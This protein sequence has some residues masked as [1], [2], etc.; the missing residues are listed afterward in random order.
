MALAYAEMFAVEF[1]AR[2]V[3]VAVKGRPSAAL[4]YRLGAKTLADCLA[5]ERA[6]I[7]SGNTH[8]VTALVE[9]RA[10]KL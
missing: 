4:I 6:V 10:M 2:L 5:D 7:R 9:V 8:E 3:S 1:G